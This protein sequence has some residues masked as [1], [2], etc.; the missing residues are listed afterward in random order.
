MLFISYCFFILFIIILADTGKLSLGFLIKI[1]HYDWWCHLILYG[2][3]YLLLDYFLKGKKIII[4]QYNLSQAICITLLLI[5]FEEIS[6]LFFLTR[7][8]SIID[9][10]IGIY[11]F[12][13]VRLLLSRFK[14]R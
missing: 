13:R 7:T 5:F 12:N 3:F 2:V 8:F 6:Q 9:I 14:G 1:P 4:K 10:I 11:L